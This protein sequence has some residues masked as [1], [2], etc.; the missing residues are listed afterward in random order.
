MFWRYSFLAD[1]MLLE[2]SLIMRNRK[3]NIVMEKR[4]KE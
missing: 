2:I 4:F 3:I 1:V